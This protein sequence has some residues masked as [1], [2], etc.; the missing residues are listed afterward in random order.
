M[1]TCQIYPLVALKLTEGSKQDRKGDRNK[2]RRRREK[3]RAKRERERQKEIKTD[4][5]E[6]DRLRQKLREI[7]GGETDMYTEGNERLPL[8]VAWGLVG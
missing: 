5:R 1:R 2:E 3:Q 6:R 7:K 4:N 8:I